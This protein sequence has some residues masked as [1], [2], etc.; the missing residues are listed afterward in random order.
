VKKSNILIFILTFGL[1]C[2]QSIA[3]ETK[4]YESKLPKL[5][6]P[7]ADKLNISPPEYAYAITI[8]NQL[9]MGYVEPEFKTLDKLDDMKAYLHSNTADKEI[10]ATLL[11]AYI[12]QFNAHRTGFATQLGIEVDKLQQFLEMINSFETTGQYQGIQAFSLPLS[13]TDDDSP[14]VEF[15]RVR[16]RCYFE[17]NT[18]NSSIRLSVRIFDK[19]F[20]AGIQQ[21][22]GF[23]NNP[24]IVE[25]VDNNDNTVKMEI[26]RYNNFSGAHKYR[27][28]SRCE[29]TKP[30]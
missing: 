4:D 5:F 25:F 10:T 20:S 19:A 1:L 22:H 15:P 23:S 16:V 26:W 7:I 6:T 28:C 30:Q 29:T 9:L 14:E 3:N 21:S 2:F 17:C 18:G 24:F 13:F 11:S 8:Y 12:K 27:D